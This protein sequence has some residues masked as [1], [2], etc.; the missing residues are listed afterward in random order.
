[1]TISHFVFPWVGIRI[2]LDSGLA[3]RNNA[4]VCI[5][6][7]PYLVCNFSHL[8]EHEVVAHYGLICISLEVNNIKDLFLCLLIINISSKRFLLVF[9]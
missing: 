4:A 3:I 8:S 2:V 1:M 9:N 7:N 6:A 5:L